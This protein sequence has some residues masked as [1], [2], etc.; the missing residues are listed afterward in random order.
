M[1]FNKHIGKYEIILRNAGHRV[2]IKYYHRNK[3][4]KYIER[5]NKKHKN[6]N[7]NKYYKEN[8]NINKY[9]HQNMNINCSIVKII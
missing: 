9:N 6:K 7:K 2:N 3:I 5:S 8:I 1:I 4:N